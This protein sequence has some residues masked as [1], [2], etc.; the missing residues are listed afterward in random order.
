MPPVYVDEGPPVE[1]GP[2]VTVDVDG[3]LFAVGP[4]GRGGTSYTWLN[5][6]NPGYGFSSGRIHST[7]GDPAMP[8]SV[9]QG[10]GR[11]S[12]G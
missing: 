11:L 1:P 6:P 3:E 10:V 2:F 12:P 5:G 7:A 9:R 8:A 4:D